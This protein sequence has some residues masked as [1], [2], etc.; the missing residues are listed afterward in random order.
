VESRSVSGNYRLSRKITSFSPGGNAPGSLPGWFK[1]ILVFIFIFLAFFLKMGT[2]AASDEE[3][4]IEGLLKLDQEWTGDFNEMA[5]RRIIRVLVTFSK[6]NYF[7]DRGTQRGATYELMREF[8]KTINKSLKKRHLKVFVIFIPVTRDQLIPALVEGRGD[9]A[10]AALTI[11]PERKQRV[12]F[13]DPLIKDMDEIVVAGPGAPKLTSIDDLSGKEIH[14]RKT[15][16]YYEHLVRINESFRKAGKPQIVIREA[17]EY[18]EDEDLLEM[19]NAGLIPMIV[20]DNYL[21]KF[22]SQIFKDITLYHKIVVNKGGEIAWMIRQN[23][24]KL[25]QVINS[26]VKSHK[27]GSLFGNIML[28]RYLKSTQYVRNSLADKD[29]E[30]F[31]STIALFRKYADTYDMDWLLVAALA[32]QESRL[33]QSLRSPAGAVGVMQLLPTT[34]AG[35]PI[36]ISNIQEIENNIHAGVKYLRWIF[37][38]YFKEENMDRLDKGLFTFAAYNAGPAK[39]ARL[40]KQAS[41]MGLDPNKWF[42]NVEVVAAKKIGRETVQYVS[43]IFKYYVAYR[44]IVDKMELKKE[45]AS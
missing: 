42:G 18:L 23:S 14:V 31:K 39:V 24:P 5:K 21:A 33:D 20:V 43:N 12:D 35:R 34:A 37:D 15:S 28:R 26:F 1:G 10:A 11:T 13:A 6:T 29:L 7:L 41:K 38:R 40:R 19:V 27:K 44:L 9:I 2:V 8:E 3:R 32:Y 45:K 36:N 22:W 30:R 16:S 4:T 17:Y 25:K